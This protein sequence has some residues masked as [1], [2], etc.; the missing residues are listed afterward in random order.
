MKFIEALKLKSKLFFLFI[1]ITIGLVAIGLIGTYNYNYMKKNMDSLYFG[2]LVPVVELNKI[3]QIYHGDLVTT[4][5]KA[6]NSEIDPNQIVFKIRQSLTDIEKNWK[7]YESHFKRDEE[8]KYV[9]YVSMEI[10]LVNRYFLKVMSLVQKGQSIEKISI[11]YLEKKM[12]HIHKTIE[13]L[14]NY[15]IEVAKY[16]R[17]SFLKNFNN[18]LIWLVFIL[19]LI[20]FFVLVISYYVFRSIQIDQTKLEITTKK[21]QRTNKKLESVSYTDSLTTLYNRRYF[22]MMYTR[23]LNRAKR[24]GEFVTFMML[25]IDFFKQYN[26]TYGH[27]QGDE[28]LKIVGRVLKDSLKRPSD[29]VFRLG[30]EEFGVLFTGT[31]E[32]NSSI[33]A[34]TICD[35]IKKEKIEHK[36]SKVNDFLTISIGVVCC[37]AI[38]TL[39]EDVLISCADDMLYQAKEKGRDQYVLSTKAIKK[40]NS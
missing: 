14:I 15:E 21:L 22:N 24:A 29:F 31:N 6:K 17:S 35:K 19:G 38:S 27:M 37:K 40:E 32:V 12:E 3:L 34:Q 23:E 13:K 5:Y 7:D 10:K 26:D 8:L 2:S 33:L 18:T 4:I 11:T 9:D 36:N 25:D 16:E 30:G 28:A 39:N 1:L 20:I